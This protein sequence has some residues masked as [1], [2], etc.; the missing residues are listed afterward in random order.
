M[1]YRLRDDLSCCRVDG[2]LIF[3]DARQ[4]RYFRLSSRMEYAL[5]AYID[6]GSD[7]EV[8][9]GEL[10]DLDLLSTHPR[11]TELDSPC[12]LESPAR[13]V[14][15]QCAYN[16]QP[17][18]SLAAEVIAAVGSMRLQLARRGLVNTLDS[19][20]AYRRAKTPRIP[21]KNGSDE[22]RLYEIASLFLR[23]RVYAPI[24]PRCL[25]DSL[26]MSRF[27]SRRRLYANIVIG[28][29]GDPFAAHAWVQA[30]DLVLN[31]TVGNANAYTP[32]LVT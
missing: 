27:L 6:G 22:G 29:T 21:R 15:E 26:A 1:Q 10:I 2:S 8:D 11:A 24:G 12:P 23:A 18:I 9:V 14:S 19:V 3:L 28:V 25:L 13:S 20:A 17:G 7:P 31:D 32:I 4:D 5:V 16:Q 30:G